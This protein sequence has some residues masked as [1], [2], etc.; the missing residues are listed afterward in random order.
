V[1][2]DAHRVGL[3]VHPYTFRDEP[4]FLAPDYALDPVKEYLQFFALGVDGVFSDFGDTA[5]RARALLPR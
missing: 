3:V 1:V 5:V 4:T 2:A